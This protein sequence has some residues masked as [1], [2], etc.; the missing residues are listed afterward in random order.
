ME[1]KQYSIY[2][3]DL[4]PTKGSEVNK[5]RPCIVI[6]PDE[7]NRFI[8]TI[9]IAPLTHMHKNY[10]SR[11]VCKVKGDKGSIMLDQIRSIDK[12]R[13]KAFLDK[14]TLKEISEVKRVINEMLC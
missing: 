8:K 5:T 6:S 2:W 14:L 13:I 9:L 7:M 12:L 11:V 10:P 1:I 4:D 3:I